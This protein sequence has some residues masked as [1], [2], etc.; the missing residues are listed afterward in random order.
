MFKLFQIEYGN[1]KEIFPIE[2]IYT[3]HD[4]G[5]YYFIFSSNL[6]LNK[7]ESLFIEDILI[8]PKWY[9]IQNGNKL[10]SLTNRYFEDY[11][12]FAVLKINDYSYKFNIQIEKFRLP[13][14]EDILLFLWENENNI[15]HN[16][17]SKSTLKA[18]VNS[19]GY[20]FGLTSKYLIF[21]EHFYE[22]FLNLFIYFKNSPQSYLRTKSKLVDYTPKHVSSSSISWIL[23]NLDCINFNDSLVD[24]PDSIKIENKYGYLDKI[25][26]DLNI[27][28]FDIY[29]NQIILGA[30]INILQILNN[31]KS[32]IN[33]NVTPSEF[34]DT[35]YVD[36][37][38][39]KKVPFLKLFDDI[40]KIESKISK[41]YSKY[42]LMFLSVIPRNELPRITATFANKNHYKSAF[43]I[44]RQS[45]ELKINL[46][47]ELQLLNIKKLSKLY[48]VYNL[49]QIVSAIS[50]KINIS[51]FAKET[52]IQSEDGILSQ[53]N[54]IN[55]EC[56][57]K[58][59][60]DLM[61]PNTE[62]NTQLTRINDGYY[63]PDYII[64][65]KYKDEISYYIIDS[66]YTK[67][68]TVKSKYL[69]ECSFK[70]ILDTGIRN[71]KFKKVSS[72][73]LLYPGDKHDDIVKSEF[74]SPQILILPSKPKAENYLFDFIDSIIKVS[75]PEY[76]L[77]SSVA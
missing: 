5:L 25:E 22:T 63:R 54:Y 65:I 30:F 27:K 73:V 28:S 42:S 36:F 14:I 3:V 41:L 69:P 66:K 77:N 31:L 40:K 44:I 10:I 48:E 51:L 12:G 20:K 64:E 50:K 17:F 53:V 59:Y 19:K 9:N 68:S 47:G 75:L 70:Y 46:D 72:M 34:S 29:E 55:D 52:Y 56:Y 39:L 11:F 18:Q 13:E 43:K 1:E 57:I 21:A 33:S 74:F 8:E 32:E 15:F 60:Y 49:H 37:K 76:L 45:K 35:K 4:L 58:V 24:Y 62:N 7:R 16:F 2:G 67:E 26:T 23:S 71:N 6:K 61:F 38:D